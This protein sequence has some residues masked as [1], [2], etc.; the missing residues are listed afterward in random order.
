MHPNAIKC[1]ADFSAYHK[2]KIGILLI[3]VIHFE[4]ETLLA[5]IL[6]DWWAIKECKIMIWRQP[7]Q[8]VK[9]TR[10]EDRLLARGLVFTM[11]VSTRV[12]FDKGESKMSIFADKMPLHI[13]VNKFYEKFWWIT[14]YF[15]RIFIEEVVIMEVDKKN[16]AVIMRNDGRFQMIS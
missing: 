7:N 14:V 1:P 10:L 3:K 9:T 5:S 13:L 16:Y 15:G 12:I 6:N 8:A 11:Y 4:E 2:E